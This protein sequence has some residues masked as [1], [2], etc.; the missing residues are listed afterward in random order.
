MLESKFQAQLIC[1]I[2]QRIPDSI[3]LK[4]DSGYLQG[5][6]DLTVLCGDKWAMLECKKSKDEPH[7]PNQDYY[8]DWADRQAF[9]RFIFP[10]N[11]EEVLYELQQALQSGGKARLSGS[12]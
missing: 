3:V 11:K 6:P 9:G 12:K 5:I 10:E 4:N 8:I 1:E 7:Q 2:A